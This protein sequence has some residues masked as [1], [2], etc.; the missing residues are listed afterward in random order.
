MSSPSSMNI[1][2][3]KALRGRRRGGVPD[4]TGSPSPPPSSGSPPSASSTASSA[5]GFSSTC[6]PPC[7]L[8]LRRAADAGA[9]PRVG[10]ALSRRDLGGVDRASRGISSHRI[11]SASGDSKPSRSDLSSHW[12]ARMMKS[13]RLLRRE[14]SGSRAYCES[15]IASSCSRTIPEEMVAIG[16]SMVRPGAPVSSAAKMPESRVMAS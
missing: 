2:G 5:W 11:T 13:S 15:L 14:E 12:R 7:N 6:N 10:P 4:E 1:E 16:K 9:E 8:A 3:S